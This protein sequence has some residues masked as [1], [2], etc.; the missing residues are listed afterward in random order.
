MS[1]KAA[2]QDETRILHEYIK[3]MACWDELLRECLRQKKTESDE[4]ET[5]CDNKKGEKTG[6]KVCHKS[7]EIKENCVPGRKL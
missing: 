2:I 4:K 7:V 5:G 1:V 3:K 6:V